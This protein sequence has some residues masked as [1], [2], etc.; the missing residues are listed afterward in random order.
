MGHDHTTIYPDS[1]R[2]LCP[3]GIRTFIRAL[4]RVELVNCAAPI[5]AGRQRLTIWRA[6]LGLFRW[7]R[8]WL[9]STMARRVAFLQCL[10]AEP[11]KER[12]FQ[13]RIAVLRWGLLAVL[14]VALAV[15]G[16]M[17]GW[18]VMLNSL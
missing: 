4:E 11:Q 1:A 12:R 15:L 2:G 18:D 3:T 9:H 8:T 17:V 5:E 14:A 13:R 7:F 6:I 10:I 16:Q